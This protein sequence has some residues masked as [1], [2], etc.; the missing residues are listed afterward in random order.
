ML[1]ITYEN[2]IAVL[3]FIAKYSLWLAFIVLIVHFLQRNYI[4]A[5]KFAA[6]SLVPLVVAFTI[7]P[8]NY[9]WYGC[10]YVV[11]AMGFERSTSFS[12]AGSERLFSLYSFLIRSVTESPAVF[13][14]ISSLLYISFYAWACR[15][16][17]GG[18]ATLSQ[19][20]LC[21]GGPFFTGYMC[22]T[23]RAGLAL[24][25][26][27]V[28]YTYVQENKKIAAIIGLAAVGVHSSAL[29]P[30]AAVVV[31]YYYNRPKT[32]IYIWVL[33]ILVSLAAG[34]YFSTLFAGLT[35]NQ[36]LNG[37]LV[38]SAE[39]ARR[40]KVGFRWDFLAYSFIPVVAGWYY[41][42]KKE[43]QDN[44]YSILYSA[45]LICNSFWVLVI[46]VPFSDRF[47][48]L[49]WFLIPF[50]LG[51]PL[52]YRNINLS[53]PYGYYCAS[54]ILMLVVKIYIG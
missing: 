14:C 26:V 32:Y 15:R 38:A 11:Y 2:L 8:V 42:I 6:L 29:L 52:L 28:A 40:Y 35:D 7:I 24:S 16:F 36:R 51:Y 53:N 46:R 30:V 25:L 41:L 1:D 10:D 34:S 12:N 13:F 21:F 3:N 47:A 18:N 33:C 27:L 19:L 44:F 48:Y 20:A 5:P 23:M 49:S 4:N 50:I 31:A 39:D 45:Y 37:Y 22:N 9:A 17:S 54:L 43:F